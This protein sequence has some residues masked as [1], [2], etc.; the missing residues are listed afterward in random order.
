MSSALMAAG[1]RWPLLTRASPTGGWRAACAG[2][3]LS[4]RRTSL[5]CL[6]GGR[7]WPPAAITGAA[8]RSTGAGSATIRCASFQ[9]GRDGEPQHR[10]R[11]HAPRTS[12]TRLSAWHSSNFRSRME[13]A[14]ESEERPQGIA[15]QRDSGMRRGSGGSTDHPRAARGRTPDGDEQHAGPRSRLPDS[16]GRYGAARASGREFV[17]GVHPCASVLAFGSRKVHKA[18]VHSRGGAD[19]EDGSV[20]AS[21]I[22]P[23]LQGAGVPI[24]RT[25][26]NTLHGMVQQQLHQGIVL[27]TDAIEPPM[28]PDG[29]TPTQFLELVHDRH[30]GQTDASAPAASRH[31]LIVALDEVADPHNVGAV[32]RSAWLLGADGV[33]VSAR[34]SAPFN[35]TVSK[36]SSGALEGWCAT[37]RLFVTRSMPT[38][39]GAYAAAEWRV[40]GTALPPASVRKQ[41]LQAE[42][43]GDSSS[44]AST[45]ANVVA[46]GKWIASS[47]LARDAPTVLVLGSEG[48]GMRANLRTAC[49]AFAFIPMT[50]IIAPKPARA[51]ARGTDGDASTGAENAPAL[52]VPDSLNVSTA[53]A[54]LLHALR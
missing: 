24:I 35:A 13:N 43:F 45:T 46:S 3:A 36:T 30:A 33:V 5:H 31:P 44:A 53:A 49:T 42:A 32:L 39:L 28:L 7:P 14:E 37:R 34:N 54:V 12:G 41:L 26:R 6:V 10:S 9:S 4:G 47:R 51:A 20:V 16:R 2:G 48:R 27:E 15:R 38:L 8:A 52:P 22:L 40:L 19:G 25:D 17:Y 23:A 50:P 18:Y 29:M 1:H 21:A 11:P